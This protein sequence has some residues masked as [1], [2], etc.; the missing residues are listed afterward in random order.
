MGERLPR[1]H[2]EELRAA[3]SATA[4][5]FHAQLHNKMEWLVDDNPRRQGL[6]SPCCNLEVK[7]SQSLYDSSLPIV[8]LAP[9]YDKAIRARHPAL[10]DRFVVL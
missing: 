4:F 6:F 8:V 3:A 9:R 5:M 2:V 7:P 1:T 10:A